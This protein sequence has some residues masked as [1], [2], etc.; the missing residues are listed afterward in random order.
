LQK[1]QTERTA[2]EAAHK[3]QVGELQKERELW[4]QRATKAEAGL[5]AYRRKERAIEEA[6]RAEEEKQQAAK[7]TESLSIWKQIGIELVEIPAGRFLYG[8]E[9]KQVE[10]ETFRIAKMPVTN[11]Q[12]KAF[13]EA[14]GHRKPEHWKGGRI[15]SQK[16]NHPVVR[17][18]WN[19]A[20]AFCYWAGV[21]LPSE[22][23]WE[24]AARGTDGRRYPWGESA[25]TKAICNFNNTVKDTTL[26][27][28][29]PKGAS[30]YGLLDMAG[31]VWEWC[32]DWFDIQQE[33]RVVRGGAFNIVADNVR[34]ACR[35]KSS[36][37]SRF[38][39]IG[40]RVAALG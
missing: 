35:S 5:E 14:T 1:A 23:Q 6:R 15:P 21:Q 19:D 34:C 10:L 25:P 30:P 31:N 29:Y 2:T 12:Y 7:H 33:H 13:V 18:D 27:G 40:F 32:I 20:Q 9:K 11:A 3:G 16:E 22:Q 38:S 37:E 28:A 8:D 24:K 39:S 36:R 26:I 17:V 4:Q